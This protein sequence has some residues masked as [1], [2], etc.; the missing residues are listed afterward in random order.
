MKTCLEGETK[1]NCPSLAV[2]WR[3]GDEV[4]MDFQL[5][6][7]LSGCPSRCS[8]ASLTLMSMVQMG[9][10]CPATLRIYQR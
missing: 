10:G 6:I 1:L 7:A 2:T 8:L 5:S 3:E 9:S 4:G